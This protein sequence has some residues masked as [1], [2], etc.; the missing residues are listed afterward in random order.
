MRIKLILNPIAGR[1]YGAKAKESILAA[2]RQSGVE[3][4]VAF[5]GQQGAGRLLARQAVAEGYDTIIAAGGDG[6]V[7]EVVN[8]M[9]GSHAALG[10]IPLG[11]GND[12]AAMMGMPDEP[13]A[14]LDRILHGPRMAVDLC[15]ANDRFYASSV[16]AGFD[17]ECTYTANH[18]LK[19]L[20]GMAVYVLSVFK[21]V[22]A[23]K[24]RRVRLVIDGEVMQ[25]DIALVAVANSR[26]YGGGMLVTP[27]A[28]ADDGFFDVCLVD[29]MSPARI[30]MLLPRLIKG[31]HLTMPEVTVYKARKV[32]LD[33]PTVSII[34]STARSSKTRAWSS[35]WSPEDL[36]AGASSSPVPPGRY[37]SLPL[38][39]GHDLGSGGPG[40][41]PCGCVPQRCSGGTGLARSGHAGAGQQESRHG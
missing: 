8:G 23:Y 11:T 7:N 22:L 4:D 25:K 5:T 20:R 41:V 17:G 34:R 10:V 27:D 28:A 12:F 39:G 32:T 3:F 31:S 38:S 19:W 36:V 14:C 33:C 9:A 26:T 16:G 18:S 15:R 35:I 29:R 6:T 24:P 2:L 13:A 1:G 30:V 21:T 40:L 37:P